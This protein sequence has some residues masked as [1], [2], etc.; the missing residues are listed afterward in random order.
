MTEQR[1]ALHAQAGV[2][3]R[4]RH[5][6]NEQSLANVGQHAMLGQF[7]RQTSA[8]ILVEGAKSDRSLDQWSKRGRPV[9]LIKGSGQRIVEHLQRHQVKSGAE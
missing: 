9:Q 5:K 7:G 3:Y 4:R 2:P 8:Q 6:E 1:I